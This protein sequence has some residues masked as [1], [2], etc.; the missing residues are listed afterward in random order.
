MI[1]Y[2]EIEPIQVGPA[3]LAPFGLL[4]ALGCIAGWIVSRREAQLRGLDPAVIDGTL[5]WAL[6]PGFFFSRF[7]EL[8]FYHPEV[9][10]A[11]PWAVLFFWQSMSSF[12]GFIGGTVGVMG[13]L[14]ATKRPI[15]PYLDC[16]AGGFIVGWFFGRLGCTIVHDHPGAFT[17]FFLGVKFPDGVRHDLGFY[18]WLF[19]IAL[20]VAVFSIDRTRLKPGALLAGVCM[21]Y[22]PV[23]FLM[24]FLRVSD[25]VY[26]GLTAAQ[27]SCILLFFVGLALKV[28]FTGPE[29]PTPAG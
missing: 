10:S 6:V 4:V 5:F 1:P 2:I 23:R 20:A 19:T 7:F 28:V 29:R 15:L 25:R 22:A 27:Y 21:V 24:D 17:T 18:E 13:Y 8:V 14:R 3:V 16:L 11:R 9:L 12:G 26:F